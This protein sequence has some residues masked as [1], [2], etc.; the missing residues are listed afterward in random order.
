MYTCMT[1]FNNVVPEQKTSIANRTY[2]F[3]ITAR[4]VYILEASG[5]P[6]STSFFP[7]LIFGQIHQPLYTKNIM[8]DLG[9]RLRPSSS[10]QGKRF[11]TENA[12]F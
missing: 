2:R 1:L 12:V 5:A 8:K 7:D 10:L 6:L 4:R 3:V 9:R 11:C